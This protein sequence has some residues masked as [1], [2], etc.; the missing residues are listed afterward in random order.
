MSENND[1]SQTI[2]VNALPPGLQAVRT[3]QAAKKSAKKDKNIQQ[4]GFPDG[5]P[6]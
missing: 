3:A 1:A 2:L 5:H 6:L 4:A